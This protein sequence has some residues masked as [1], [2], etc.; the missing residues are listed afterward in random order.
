[1]E[2][3]IFR[4]LPVPVIVRI[5]ENVKNWEIAHVLHSGLLV[6]SKITV[7][8]AKPLTS[9]LAGFASKHGVSVMVQDETAWLNWARSW[10]A[11]DA[12][13]DGRIRIIG[14]TRTKVAEAIDGSVD[15]AIWDH[16]VTYSGRVEMIP[17]LHEQAVALTNHRFGDPTPIT[18]GILEDHVVDY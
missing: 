5:G 12:G 11:H 15:I 10:A 14:E 18:K 6:G 13:Y 16:P 4:C 9:G 2:R 7:S 17:F 3:N 1:M 8:T